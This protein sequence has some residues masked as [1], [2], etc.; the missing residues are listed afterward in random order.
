[1]LAELALRKWN[2]VC[3]P[4]QVV[5]EKKRYLVSWTDLFTVN[6]FHSST[7][8]QVEIL[9]SK[10]DVLDYL[11]WCQFSESC[12]SLDEYLKLFPVYIYILDKLGI[13]PLSEKDIKQKV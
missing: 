10:Q 6:T 5:D 7:P 13:Q 2:E 12:K 11:K 3:D 9:E 1:M 4:I 8:Q